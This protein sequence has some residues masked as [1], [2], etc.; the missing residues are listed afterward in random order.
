[1]ADSPADPKDSLNEGQL[2]YIQDKGEIKTQ[3]IYE[4]SGDGFKKSGETI[5]LPASVTVKDVKK[6]FKIDGTDVDNKRLIETY[7]GW[8]LDD[9]KVRPHLISDKHTALTKGIIAVEAADSLS[10]GSGKSLSKIPVE[11]ADRLFKL[12]YA[13]LIDKEGIWQKSFEIDSDSK[14]YTDLA[15]VLK[16]TCRMWNLSLRAVFELAETLTKTLDSTYASITKCREAI[17]NVERFL[18]KSEQYK[19]CGQINGQLMKHASC[20][21]YTSDAADE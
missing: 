14:K 12:Y 19:A 10:T 18:K 1:M 5:P 9:D 3:D 6:H 13:L 11:E 20:L 15:R 2:L 21:L 7:Y 16:A 4:T 17:E 8:I